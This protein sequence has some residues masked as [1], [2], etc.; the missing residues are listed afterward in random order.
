MA[1]N[2]AHVTSATDVTVSGLSISSI[3][4]SN[5][6]LASDYT[7]ASN[8]A[9]VAATIVPVTLTPTLTD[10]GVAKTY[11]GTTAA[12]TGFTPTYSY[13][14][15]ISGDT[16]ASLSDTS[17]VY[18]SAHVASATDVTVSG[19]SISSITGSNGSLASDYSLASHNANVAATITPAPLTIGLSNVTDVT[20]TY[21]GTTAAPSGFSPTYS[22]VGLVAG[23]SATLSSSATP[24]FNSPHVASATAITQGG[25]SLTSITGNGS[26]NSVLGDYTLSNTTA[27]TGA[28]VA[29]I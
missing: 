28:G 17:V 10:S 23:D 8:S 26:D 22:F 5:G 27:S 19:L 24:V 1:Y 3:T 16:G 29:S 25:L 6:S 14:G 12:P 15:L 2:S 9:S 7:L 4:G 18:N 11:N 21:D 13:S 20:K